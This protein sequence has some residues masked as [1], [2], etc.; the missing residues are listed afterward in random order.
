MSKIID[1]LLP[2]ILTSLRHGLTAFGVWLIAVAMSH[3][4]GKLVFESSGLT[5]DQIQQAIIGVGVAVAGYVLGLVKS[6]AAA[7]DKAASEAIAAAAA[8]AAVKALATK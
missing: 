6:Y 5:A 4:V 7:K 3:P 8:T 1:V 2:F